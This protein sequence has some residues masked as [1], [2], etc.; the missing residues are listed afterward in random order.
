ML[1]INN[2]VQIRFLE[3]SISSK[4]SLY[5]YKVPFIEIYDYLKTISFL[6]FKGYIV[7]VSFLVK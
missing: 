2:I 1:S 7:D 3:I 6:L 5:I 4:S